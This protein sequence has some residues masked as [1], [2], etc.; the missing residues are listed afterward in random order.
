MKESI[1]MYTL[2]TLIEVLSAAGAAN[3]AK[4]VEQALMQPLEL[5]GP[6]RSHTLYYRGSPPPVNMEGRIDRLRVVTH[7]TGVLFDVELYLADGCITLEKISEHFPDL[8]FA[9]LTPSPAP[10]A[11]A[12][13]ATRRLEVPVLFSFQNKSQDCLYSISIDYQSRIDEY[14]IP[15]PEKNN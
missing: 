8:Y 2:W 6:P 5:E 3:G 7:S 11:T 13:Y 15:P 10:D 4:G 9:Y 14:G 12:S 1:A